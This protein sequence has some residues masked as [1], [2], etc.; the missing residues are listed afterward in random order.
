MNHEYILFLNRFFTGFKHVVE[1]LVQIV[2]RLHRGF[3]PLKK[4]ETTLTQPLF[5]M[6][7]IPFHWY[8]EGL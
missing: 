1:D 7:N 6:K 8:F 3:E 4:V 5:G 2:F